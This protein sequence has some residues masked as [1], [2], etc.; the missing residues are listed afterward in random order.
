MRKRG[1][2][3]HLSLLIISIGALTLSLFSPLSLPQATAKP[4]LVTCVNL[5]TE[6]ERVSRTGECR[7]GRE[8]QAN[9]HKISSDSAIASGPN[10]KVITTCSDSE[11]SSTTYRIIR[12][13]CARNQT[14]TNFSR[15]GALPAKPVIAEAVGYSHDSAFLS[16]AKD[17]AESLDAPVAFYT[18]TATRVS[19][20]TESRIETQRIYFWRDLR[21]VIS[22][23]QS[24]TTY[25]LTVTA[26]TVDGTSEVSLSS[27]PVTT[28]AYVPP[29]STSSSSNAGPASMLTVSR[30]SVG[31]S[32]GVAFST[33]PQIAIQDASGNTVT[34]STAVVT[35]TISA[36]GS[37]V[38]TTSATASGGIA[39]FNNLGVRGFG[40]TAYTITYA[41]TGLTSAIEV[42]TPAAYALG[43][44]GPGGGKIYYIAPN[45]NGFPCG[46]P[47]TS[48]CFYLEVAPSNWKADDL[49]PWAIVTSNV[50]DIPD[51]GGFS[52]GTFDSIGLGFQYSEYIVAQN[53]NPYDPTTPFA[54]GAARAYQPTVS[55]VTYSDWYLPSTAELNTLCQWSRGLTQS[56][57][58]ECRLGS[59]NSP[60]FG[61]QSSSLGGTYW[62][63]SENGASTN[64]KISV[65]STAGGVAG[66]TKT[67]PQ[68]VRP[69]RAF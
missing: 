33:Q 8:A 48:T 64:G 22:G 51:G 47:R 27:I 36:R 55:G 24:L 7:P 10:L 16:L 50:A 46:A 21:L 14:I 20:A 67:N 6:K 4:A 68:R 42:V 38:G 58:T 30:S 63:S 25:T 35:A 57:T 52:D 5:V 15:S 26:T 17:P 40:G 34:S 28:A 32:A 61:A 45:A 29:K 62:A 69:I 1:L 23:L 60:T 11:K 39:T 56:F 19:S 2:R 66:S 43:A 37:L 54:A 9:W 3:S 18:I 44:T 12:K 13:R 65:I 59:D 41:T 53:V 31:T 49:M